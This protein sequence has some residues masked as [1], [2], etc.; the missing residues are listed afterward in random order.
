VADAEETWCFSQ[1]TQCHLGRPAPID[2]HLA[3]FGTPS[4]VRFTLSLLHHKACLSGHPAS[5]II[6]T[7]QPVPFSMAPIHHGHLSLGQYIYLTSMASLTAVGTCS[8]LGWDLTLLL[9]PALDA[10]LYGLLDLA[11]LMML[12]KMKPT[13]ISIY[14][15]IPKESASQILNLKPIMI[16]PWLI[17]KN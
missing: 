2:Y 11:I 10:T 16:E 3:C 1:S 12:Q 5:T 17:W 6:P 14:L 9:N 4:P 13:N 7:H 8:L 15:N